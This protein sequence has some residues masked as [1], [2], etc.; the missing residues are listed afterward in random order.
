M[1]N[2]I[3]I[4]NLH[5]N[6][7]AQNANINIGSTLQNS[8]TSNIKLFGANF[9]MGDFSPASS[10]IITVTQDSDKSDQGQTENP[11]S[12]NSSQ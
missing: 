1:P 8:H 4:F 11:S 5:V 3:K 12:P 10:L 9:S 2:Q 6:G 7:M